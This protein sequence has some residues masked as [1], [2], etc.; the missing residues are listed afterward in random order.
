M[1]RKRHN[2]LGA[3]PPTP[4]RPREYYTERE[5]AFNEGK[6]II[7]DYRPGIKKKTHYVEASRDEYAP[8][9]RLP[10]FTIVLI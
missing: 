7:R 3:E 1:G 9:Y 2:I 4:L 8:P 10:C 6:R 5:N